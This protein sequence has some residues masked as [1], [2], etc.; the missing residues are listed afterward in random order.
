LV[1]VSFQSKHGSGNPTPSA[2]PGWATAP[3]FAIYSEHATGVDLRLFEDADAPAEN[4]RVRMT[5]QS[6]EAKAIATARPM[7]LSA[8]VITVVKS[9]NRPWPV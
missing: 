9:C 8:P 5:E 3:N 7:P 4:I 1:Y 6:D 2:R